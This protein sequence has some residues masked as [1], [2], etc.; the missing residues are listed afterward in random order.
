M[1]F[2]HRLFKEAQEREKRKNDRTKISQFTFSPK[3][4][5]VRP[6][7]GTERVH[8]RDTGERLFARSKK[9]EQK[10]KEREERRLRNET[11]NCTFEPAFVLSNKRRPTKPVIQSSPATFKRRVKQIF[12]KID[13]DKSGA[14]SLRELKKG[15]MTVPELSE[16]VAPGRSRGAY[17]EMAQQAN[18]TDG[19]SFTQFLQFCTKATTLRHLNTFERRVYLAKWMLMKVIVSIRMN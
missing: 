16:I 8:K 2:G 19:V 7:D 13:R 17:E 15:M 1:S 12:T 9:I 18:D 3:L 11:Q 4:V 6:S 5:S 14:L 10:Q